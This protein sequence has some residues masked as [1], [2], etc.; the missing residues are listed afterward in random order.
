MTRDPAFTL[1]D[2]KI[3]FQ[4]GDSLLTA[5]LANHRY[6]PHLCAHPDF[7][8]HGSCRVCLVE[9]DGRNR[10]ACT[11]AAQS[12]MTIRSN[13]EPLN[14]M[15]RQLLQ[16]L[17]VEGNHFC[18]GCEQSGQCQLQATAYELGMADLH[19]PPLNPRRKLDASHPDL[20]LDRD[21]CIGCELC[22]KAS[23]QV[24]QK[25]VF[26]LGGRGTRTQLV[27]NSEHNQ[28][29]ETDMAADDRAAHVCPVG[30]ILFKTGNYARVAGQRLY[31]LQ[32]ISAIGNHRA[33]DFDLPSTP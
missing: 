29:G 28:L 6:I 9:V 1:D 2:I 16:L 3:E 13:I 4:P 23:S 19:Y 17:F 7:S 21:R 14:A 20:L 22:V 26:S 32:P 33:E 24:D 31:D 15:R 10:P 12:G 5:A 30:V 27:V 8:A 25:H 18:P 11:T